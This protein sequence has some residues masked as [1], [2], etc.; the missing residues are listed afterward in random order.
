MAGPE[1]V[2]SFLKMKL[3]Q[4]T[5]SLTEAFRK[6][7]KSNTGFLSQADFEDCLRDFNIRL[8]RQALAAVVA[9]YDINGDGFV[10][11]EEFCAVM[12]GAPPSAKLKAAPA[13][14]GPGGA[15]AVAQ[16]EENMRRI[17][18][19]TTTSLTQAF[20][21]INR[22]RSGFVEPKELERIFKLANLV[23]SAEEL[24]QILKHYD[25]NKDGKIDINELQKAL[26]RDVQRFEGHAARGQKRPR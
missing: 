17:M 14:A 6:L 11:Y 18:Y 1:Q 24:K 16:A 9:K 15:S 20:L 5:K 21:H 7:D 3:E 19:A 26:Q 4:R 25:T 23:L 8:T 13:I 10:S 12:T 2:A 22:N